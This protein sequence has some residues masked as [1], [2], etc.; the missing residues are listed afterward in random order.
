MDES[1]DAKVSLFVQRA[2]DAG[3]ELVIQLEKDASN[4]YGHAYSL[5]EDGDYACCEATFRQSYTKETENQLTGYIC[6]AIAE[7]ANSD[8]SYPI[9]ILFPAGYHTRIA[10]IPGKDL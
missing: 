8:N 6:S 9:K 10:E 4:I 1:I 7:R 2:R 3:S 5:D